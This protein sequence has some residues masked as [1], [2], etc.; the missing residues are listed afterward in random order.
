MDCRKELSIIKMSK[1]DFKINFE[2]FEIPYGKKFYLADHFLFL[3]CLDNYRFSRKVN[4]FV[5]DNVNI[6]IIE[7]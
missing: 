1:K 4:N 2:Y 6:I 3:F 5:G 7:N